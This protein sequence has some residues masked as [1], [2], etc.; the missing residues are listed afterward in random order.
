MPDRLTGR[1]LAI[2]TGHALSLALF[3]DGSLVARHDEPVD[4]GHAE[5]LAPA[6]S[7]LLAGGSAVPARCE[8]VVFEVGPGSFTG[9]R[10]GAAAARALALAWEAGLFGVRSTLLVAARVRALGVVGPLAVAL[11]A[12]RGQIWLERFA[13]GEG[14]HGLSSL[15]APVAVDPGAVPDLAGF[16]RAGSAMWDAPSLRLLPEAASIAHLDEADL[17]APDLLYV[18]MAGYDAAA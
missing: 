9:L 5:R 3:E 15:G 13:G 1:T 18:R 11:K 4:R 16:T 6:L 2:A 10:I 8:R 12:P 14:R 17:S 7:D